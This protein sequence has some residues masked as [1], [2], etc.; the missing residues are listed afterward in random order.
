MMD[1]SGDMNS[2]RSILPKV[3]ESKL[4]CYDGVCS[5]CFSHSVVCNNGV[6]NNWWTR[7]MFL[8]SNRL[9]NLN[10]NDNDKQLL[11]EILKMKLSVAAV[12]QMKLYTNTQKCEA[13]N[14]ALSVSL[15][16]NDIFATMEGRTSSAIHRINNDPGTSSIKKCESNQK[17]L[18]INSFNT[19]TKFKNI[20]NLSVQPKP[21]QTTE[22][23]S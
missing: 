15:P 18:N 7:Y 6:N 8:A 12:E 11:L 21:N 23:D 2:L 9:F 3:L 16:K 19:V 1:F 20:P 22:K 10:K 17:L 14:R 13:V 5:R 4:T